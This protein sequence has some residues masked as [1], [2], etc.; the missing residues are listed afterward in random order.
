[1]N[2]NDNIFTSNSNNNSGGC[3]LNTYLCT[4]TSHGICSTSHNHPMRYRWIPSLL[5]RRQLMLQDVK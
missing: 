4:S 2:N 1:M 5:H 3:L